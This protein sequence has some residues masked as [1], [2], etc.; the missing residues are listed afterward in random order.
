M[1][2]PD[3]RTMT[4]EDRVKAVRPLVADGLSSTQIA[5]C[6]RNV[7][8]NAIIGLCRRQNM[9]LTGGK[10][11][12]HKVGAERRAVDTELKQREPRKPRP[13]RRP[14]NRLRPSV[15]RPKV[16]PKQPTVPVDPQP[17]PA[18]E[19]LPASAV[20]F[21]EALDRGLCKWPLWDRF[22]GP[23]VSMC[24]GAPRDS[25]RP[26]CTDHMTRQAGRGSEIE[27][28]AHRILEAYAVK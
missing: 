1:S 18:L 25:G 3:W 4:T 12:W 2:R 17:L 22:E 13:P 6:F 8:R 5:A 20:T 19:P 9:T 16:T 7:T 14:R 21:M 24:C 11:W 10:E 23:D 27:R 26:Y 15:A 28:S